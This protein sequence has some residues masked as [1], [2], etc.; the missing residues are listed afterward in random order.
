MTFCVLRYIF[1]NKSFSKT[2]KI[3]YHQ[4]HYRNLGWKRSESP[5]WT[6]LNKKGDWSRG[7]VISPCSVWNICHPAF[8]TTWLT[9]W[10]PLQRDLE[11]RALDGY[12][13][14]WLGTL[15]NDISTAIKCPRGAHWSFLTNQRIWKH[16]YQGSKAT[17]EQLILDFTISRYVKTNLLLL[18][19]HLSWPSQ[20]SKVL[21]HVPFLHNGSPGRQVDRR[22]GMISSN[23]KNYVLS[24]FNPQGKKLHQLHLHQRRDWF[25]VACVVIFKHANLTRKTKTSGVP[26]TW[27]MEN[28]SFISKGV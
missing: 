7:L 16:D 3:C 20:P 2:T 19:W 8:P 6:D 27:E 18:T 21:P 26:D 25:Q 1:P 10:N 28:I 13:V 23:H 12:W 5:I 9:S 22:R 14:V 17:P 15:E 4:L 24:D 11:A